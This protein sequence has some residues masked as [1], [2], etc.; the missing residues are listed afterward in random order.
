[1][2]A[3]PV[4]GLLLL[5]SL[6][7]TQ[8]AA[9][10]MPRIAII[11]DDLGFRHAEG[12][13]AV[14]LPGPVACAVIP[15]APHATAMAEAAHRRG[16]EVLMHLP[17][18]SVDPTR[19]VG[20]DGITLSTTRR[21]LR[22]LVRAGL[23]GVPHASGV[24]NHM[25]SLI[26]RH[27]GHMTWLMQELARERL[28]FVDSVTTGASVALSMAREQGVPA[29]KRDL[30]LDR[31]DMTEAQIDA[32]LT[33]LVAIARRRGYAVGIA[34]PF[35]ATMAVLERRLAALGASGIRL[36]TVAELV[37][38]TDPASAASTPLT[39]AD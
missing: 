7:L 8:A 29:L 22:R 12:M 21:D 14:N 33:R 19:P 34:H 28:F 16:K 17:M 26:T 35:P 5:A 10:G 27:P 39:T 18:Q 6:A 15:N 11:V 36:V 30:F 32:R 24:N 13:R 3:A 25:G 20:E 38:E 37:A 31:E 23:D 4:R 2:I 9:A 1:M